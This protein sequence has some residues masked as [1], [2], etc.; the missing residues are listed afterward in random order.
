MAS[1]EQLYCDYITELKMYNP[2]LMF[3]DNTRIFKNFKEVSAFSDLEWIDIYDGVE[4]VGFILL[5]NGSHCPINYDWFVMECYIDAKHRR[6]HL[7]RHAMD[8][9]VQTHQGKIGLFVLCQNLVAGSFWNNYTSRTTIWPHLQL[10]KIPVM[11]TSV[12]SSIDCYELAFEISDKNDCSQNK[13][14]QTI[15]AY[16]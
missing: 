3:M 8:Q 10:T 13:R 7:M 5:T 4:C 9:M 15:P 1:R 6:N 14:A 11:K 16:E 2:N 12:P